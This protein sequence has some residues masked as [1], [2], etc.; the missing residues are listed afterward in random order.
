M[1]ESQVV[2]FAERYVTPG[3]R[4]IYS[5]DF[6]VKSV[7]HER[8]DAEIPDIAAISRKGGITAILA[9][10]G[11]FGNA[12]SLEFVAQYL[13]QKLS[14]DVPY[15]PENATSAAQ[16]FA[17]TLKPGDV[18]VLGN[19]RMNSGE[20]RN[21]LV[22]AAEYGMLGDQVV[23]GGFGKAHRT[24]ASNVG[25]LECRRGYISSSHDDEMARLELWT[26]KKPDKYSVAVLGGMKKEK[27]TQGLL[28][29]AKDYDAIIPGGI[30]LNALLKHKYGFVGN[31]VVDDG[32]KT[33]ENEIEFAL[34]QYGDKIILPS[35]VIVADRDGNRWT[36]IG[37]ANL[38][39]LERVPEGSSIVSY[40]MH[41]DQQC[42]LAR[43]AQYNGR[44]VVAGT[45][46]IPSLPESKASKQLE[47]WLK[48]IGP[49]ALILGGDTAQEL[50]AER[51]CV[52]TGGG[53]AL[54]FLT[55]GTTAAYEALKQNYKERGEP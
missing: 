29:F 37:R 16:E 1:N 44:L 41:F 51:A 12:R 42:A 45:P 48:E 50:R 53:A 54:T 47:Y 35:E 26:G 36:N 40:P 14:R 23:V 7:P 49:N 9:H 18:A 38:V 39:H 28:G 13:S 52:S 19:T 6:N 33:F 21:E 43:V 55:T 20:E 27:I 2:R 25:V 34:Q 24:N 8:V 5:A 4:W 17:K 15:F 11:R 22:L 30:V 10:E 32:G 31:S 3:S 46:D